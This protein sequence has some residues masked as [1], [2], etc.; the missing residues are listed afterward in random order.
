M[1]TIIQGHGC[2]F[3]HSGDGSGPKVVELSTLWKIMT[4]KRGDRALNS[5]KVLLGLP[6]LPKLSFPEQPGHEKEKLMN[7]ADGVLLKTLFRGLD[8]S[9]LKKKQDFAR[10][11]LAALGSP[12]EGSLDSRFANIKIIQ[13]SPDVIIVKGSDDLRSSPRFVVF[14]VIKMFAPACNPSC[15]FY[16]RGVFSYLK[17][18]G[19]SY[20]EGLTGD[21][22]R[23]TASA[24]PSSSVSWSLDDDHSDVTAYERTLGAKSSGLVWGRSPYNQGAKALLGDLPIFILVMMKLRT[25]EA[26]SFQSQAFHT[27][28]V[29]MGGNDEVALAISGHWRE[30]REAVQPCNQLLQ[31]LGGAV[32]ADQ[33]AV[34]G[35]RAAHT[36]CDDLHRKRM[37]D[38]EYEDLR[39]ANKI[40]QQRRALALEDETKTRQLALEDET[41]KKQLALEDETK[42]KQLALED[43]T[44]KRQLALKGEMKKSQDDAKRR[45]IQMEAEKAKSKAEMVETLAKSQAEMAETLA[46]R[47]A[48]MAE[49]LA[50]SKA[51]R[52]ETLAKSQATLRDESTTRQNLESE[53]KEQ[54]RVANA[55]R[56][57][58]A[59]FEN[60]AKTDHYLLEKAIHEG[61]TRAALSKDEISQEAAD[62]ILLPRRKFIN[63]CLSKILS[64]EKLSEVTKVYTDFQI[65]F[66]TAYLRG[67]FSPKPQTDW[68]NGCADAKRGKVR[69]Y[70]EDLPAIRTYAEKLLNEKKKAPAD[71]TTLS[72]LFGK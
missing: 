37:E 49:T 56:E 33:E 59:K 63:L 51:E 4:G 6:E 50:K 35:T 61:K 44:K 36:P 66:N 67:D 17:S 22:S 31:F 3:A 53:R 39:H 26:R 54:A 29:M 16:N 68:E 46:K 19:V 18:C 65:R 45:K 13:D 70:T 28:V 7:C 71:Q 24:N 34:T 62:H 23:D 32:A 58:H 40:S 30:Q 2:Y 72:A 21:I 60:D 20:P 52:A 41:K 55:A 43:E 12:L 57:D 69:W 8:A 10:E 11:V 47:Q 25:K 1:A 42:K 64:D 14:S 48:E 9:T 27:G 15:V 38:Q 5:T